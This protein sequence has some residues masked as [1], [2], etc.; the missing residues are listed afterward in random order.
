MEFIVTLCAKQIGKEQNQDMQELKQT[1]D[2]TL[3]LL[4]TSV[5][6]LES[7]LWALLLQ[8]FLSPEYEEA[9]V[10]LLRC[11]TYLASK[12]LAKEPSE[13]AFVRSLICL[14][15]PTTNFKGTF[16]LNFLRNIKPC[17]NEEYKPVWDTQIP[18]LSKYLEQNYDALNEKVID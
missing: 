10:I 17:S 5:P 6:V 12:G 7:T 3:Y 16:A 14:T 1:A 13:A 2:N 8:C 9:N 11:L 4:S 15:K 18:H